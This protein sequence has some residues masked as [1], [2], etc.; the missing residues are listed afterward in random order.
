MKTPSSANTANL[1]K[2]ICDFPA[3]TAT[4]G[5]IYYNVSADVSVEIANFLPR[6]GTLFY[7]NANRAPS[8]KTTPFFVK[9]GTRIRA[10]FGS[11]RGGWGLSITNSNHFGA[12]HA[13]T[14]N[15]DV[16]GPKHPNCGD[17]STNLGA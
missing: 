11:K 8:S 7:K 2:I 12:I 15:D 4:V 1:L 10:L 13:N 17:A 3:F 6:K 5:F 16:M 14:Y 9:S